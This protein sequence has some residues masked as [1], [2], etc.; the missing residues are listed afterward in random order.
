MDQSSFDAVHFQILIIVVCWQ[1]FSVTV[2]LNNV[3]ICAPHIL[4]SA[5]LKYW[6]EISEMCSWKMQHASPAS[7][8]DISHHWW[9]STF[10]SRSTFKDREPKILAFL[11][12]Y[13]PILFFF[14]ANLC[15]W[16]Y[17]L[18]AKTT[19]WQTKNDKYQLCQHLRTSAEIPFNENMFQM[20]IS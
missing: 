19:L 2:W 4:M 1:F 3:Q 10:S 12:P 9:W 14:A 16:V 17:L 20:P 11:D 6:F 8:A 13:W 5:N 15:T 18:Q 7:I